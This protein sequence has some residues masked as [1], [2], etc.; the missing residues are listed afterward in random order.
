MT[1]ATE[2][3]VSV[4]LPVHNGGLSIRYAIDAILA[5][6]YKEYRLFVSDNASTDDTAEIVAEYTARD[7]RIEYSRLDSMIS[8][9]DNWRRCYEHAD[10]PYFMWAADDDLRSENYLEVLVD[11]LEKDQSA[12]LAFSDYSRFTRYDLSDAVEQAFGFPGTRGVSFAERVYASWRLA[13]QVYGLFRTAALRDY[14][15]V[16]LGGYSEQPLLAYVATRGEIIRPVGARF[17]YHAGEAVK[18]KFESKVERRRYL[19]GLRD[20]LGVFP[21]VRAHWCCAEV[22]ATAP[23]ATGWTRHRIPIFLSSYLTWKKDGLKNRVY[24]RSPALL[25]R[26]WRSLRGQVAT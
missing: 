17:F 14:E 2:R 20:P 26:V 5:Q 1:A 15:W 22:A 24:R 9:L 19:S 3:R 23:R 25:K 10:T 4:L 16:Y 12:S 11:A 18:E 8:A 21:D 13:H 7:S 6:T